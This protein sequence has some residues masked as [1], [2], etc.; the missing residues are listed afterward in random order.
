[1]AL[2]VYMASNSSSSLKLNVIISEGNM[3]RVHKWINGL[4]FSL[5][6]RYNGGLMVISPGCYVR[7][8]K[9]ET[10]TR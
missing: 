8:P 6:L 5:G 1:M 3:R 4:F 10:R 9:F 7:R 2:H